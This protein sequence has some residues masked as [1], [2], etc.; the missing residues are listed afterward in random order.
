VAST[1]GTGGGII[2]EMGGLA[3][4]QSMS[5]DKQGNDRGGRSE[6]ALIQWLID[7]GL[8]K[9]DGKGRLKYE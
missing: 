7:M 9:R 1:D 8:R 6:E 4:Y 2:E 3:V 5:S